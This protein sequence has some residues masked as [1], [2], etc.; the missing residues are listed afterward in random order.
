LER[1]IRAADDLDRDVP[2]GVGG[3]MR[4]KPQRVGVSTPAGS[5]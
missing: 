1:V 5:T 4:T 2:A 3:G